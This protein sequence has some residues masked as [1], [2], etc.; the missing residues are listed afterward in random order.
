MSLLVA[1]VKQKCCEYQFEVF[2]LTRPGTESTSNVSVADYLSA[3][4]ADGKT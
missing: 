2:G 1:K 3:R 4:P